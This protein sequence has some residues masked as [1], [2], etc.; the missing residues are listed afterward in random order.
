MIWYGVHTV[1]DEKRGTRHAVSLAAEDD[2]VTGQSK[3]EK[4]NSQPP[5]IGQ[6]AKNSQI[7]E[8]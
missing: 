4:A 5:R 6:A 1:R 2:T 8:T 7:L 3:D